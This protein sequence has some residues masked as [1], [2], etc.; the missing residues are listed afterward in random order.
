MAGSARNL[1]GSARSGQQ[2]ASPGRSMGQVGSD[3]SVNFI[4]Y[5]KYPSLARRGSVLSKDGPASSSLY[6]RGS[7]F[8]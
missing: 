3:E 6:R 1:M 5:Y 2:R 4:N 7:V 8:S